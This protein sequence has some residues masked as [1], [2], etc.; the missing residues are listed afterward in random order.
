[1]TRFMNC[2]EEILLRMT[3]PQGKLL[4]TGNF[5]ALQYTALVLD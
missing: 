3:T 2:N 4:T 5:I 1:M